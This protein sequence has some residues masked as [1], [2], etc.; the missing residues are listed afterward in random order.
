MKNQNCWRGSL[1]AS[2]L[3]AFAILTFAAPL[4]AGGNP[5]SARATKS[6]K[7]GLWMTDALGF[8]ELNRNQALLAFGNPPAV[9][10]GVPSTSMEI[11]GEH[12]ATLAAKIAKG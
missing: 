6:L 11:S 5:P 10:G 7:Q 9:T 3:F 12:I 1:R 8:T 2:L 4:H